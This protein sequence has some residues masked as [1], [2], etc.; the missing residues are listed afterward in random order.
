MQFKKI[1]IIFY[2]FNLQSFNI[3]LKTGIKTF[4]CCG[5]LKEKL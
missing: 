5:S 3:S 1:G 2:I 4:N